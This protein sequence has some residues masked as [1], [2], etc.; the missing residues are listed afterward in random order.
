MLAERHFHEELQ[1][2][3][4]MLLAM[5][6]LVLEI[7]DDAVESILHGDVAQAERVIAERGRVDSLE[8]AIEERCLALIALH[9]P[10][11]VDL[12]MIVTAIN[13]IRD[14]ERVDDISIDICHEAV[15]IQRAQARP[16]ALFDLPELA[17]VSARML[18]DAVRSFVNREPAAAR[19]VCERD[20][21]AD[22][23]WLKIQEDAIAFAEKHPEA[24]RACV[25]ILAVGRALERVADHST[26]IGEMVV[27]LM[28]AKIIKHHHDQETCS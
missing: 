21:E 4:D 24:V 9:Q 19:A 8:V 20:D 2:V 15:F 17:A 22:A 27:Y 7:F 10:V 12:R 13:I 25:H 23:L 11:A 14:L 18:H 6:S 5:G 3:N 16:P 1:E 28:T 26:N